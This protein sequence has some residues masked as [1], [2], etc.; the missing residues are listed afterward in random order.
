MGFLSTHFEAFGRSLD[1]VDAVLDEHCPL[2]KKIDELL[3]FA[4][5]IKARSRPCVRKHFRG[6]LKAGA[7]PEEIAYVF[8]LAMREAAGAD[9]CWTHGIISDLADAAPDGSCGCG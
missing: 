7:S 3:R 5:S 9:D 4:L 1:R 8:A 2:E 6:A